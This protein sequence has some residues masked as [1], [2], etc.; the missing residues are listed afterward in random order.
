VSV[1]PRFDLE[2]LGFFRFWWE[3]SGPE[4]LDQGIYVP[5]YVAYENEIFCVANVGVDRQSVV[6]I[7]VYVVRVAS[8]EWCRVMRWGGG[9]KGA[10]V[11]ECGGIV[12]YLG[13]QTERLAM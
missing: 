2:P 4:V 13:G 12:P 10:A 9:C 11:W 1:G 8:G 5:L 6:G 3:Q 7:A